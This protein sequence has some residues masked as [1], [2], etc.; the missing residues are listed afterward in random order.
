MRREQAG[1]TRSQEGIDG[2]TWNILGQI[3]VPKSVTDESF[4]WHA[5]FPAGTFVPPHSHPTQD[6]YLYILEGR[7]DFWLNGQDTYATAGDTVRLPMGEPHGIF[8]KS[9][10]TVKCLFWVAPT[11]R[12]FDLFQGI[13]G[14]PE[15]NPEEVV[16]LS[17]QHEVIFLPPPPG[18]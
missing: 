2:I 16:K 17:A 1:I 13:H 18:S 7:L 6:E 12:L 4:S 14:M 5:T 8:N 15:Q 3:Y 9:G 10:E 11:R